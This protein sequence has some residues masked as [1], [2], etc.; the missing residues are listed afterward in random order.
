M[1]AC[2]GPGHHHGGEVL[3]QDSP[4][5]EEDGTILREHCGGVTIRQG[6]RRGRRCLRRQGNTERT[7]SQELLKGF[8]E[9]R[10]AL[11]NVDDKQRQFSIILSFF[12]SFIVKGLYSTRFMTSSFIN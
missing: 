6:P 4:G 8:W 3:L 10:D 5:G 12:R 9:A 1:C 2:A 7:V 11:P